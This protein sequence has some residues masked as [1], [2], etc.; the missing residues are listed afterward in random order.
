MHQQSLELGLYE[1]F[2]L[3]KSDIQCQ[4]KLPIILTIICYVLYVVTHASTFCKDFMSSTKTAFLQATHTHVLVEP[5]QNYF[6]R[7]GSNWRY[8]LQ[9]IC[10]PGRPALP[11]LDRRE[12]NKIVMNLIIV[13]LSSTILWF[14]VSAP[15]LYSQGIFTYMHFSSLFPWFQL[16]IITTLKVIKIWSWRRLQA[17][18]ASTFNLPHACWSCWITLQSTYCLHSLLIAKSL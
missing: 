16:Y 13:P 17:N 8:W 10:N 12:A 2:V 3:Q 15:A 14:V 11:V 4:E 18:K 6:C 5:A 1:G 9:G 7:F